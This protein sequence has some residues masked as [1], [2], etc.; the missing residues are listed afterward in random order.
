M[1]GCF[2]SFERLV[3]LIDYPAV[4]ASFPLLSIKTRTKPVRELSVNAIY[5]KKT[6]NKYMRHSEIDFLVF[7]ETTRSY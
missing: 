2:E 6:F 7:L 4:S 3:C 1:R 5:T